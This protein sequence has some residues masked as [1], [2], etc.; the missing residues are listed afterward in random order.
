MGIS[1]SG[2]GPRRIVA[3]SDWVWGGAVEDWGLDVLGFGP[4]LQIEKLCHRVGG[5]TDY[6]KE[7][8]SRWLVRVKDR[9]VGRM[10][11]CQRHC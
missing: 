6:L 3:H 2:V 1:C 4:L 5:L 7:Y 11:N 10:L 8:H 9:N